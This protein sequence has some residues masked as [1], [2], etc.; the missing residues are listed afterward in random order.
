MLGKIIG[1]LTGRH[2]SAPPKS[3]PLIAIDTAP[4][5]QSQS[6]FDLPLFN[7]SDEAPPKS[8]TKPNA[9]TFMKTAEASPPKEEPKPDLFGNL[10]VKTINPEPSKTTA[11]SSFSF[12]NKEPEKKSV[13]QGIDLDFAMS[14]APEP[15]PLDVLSSIDLE[16]AFDQPQRT[17]IGSQQPIFSQGK[18]QQARPY[19][20]PQG[21]LQGMNPQP[22]YNSGIRPHFIVPGAQ[23]QVS[24]TQQSLYTKEEAATDK[25]DDKY[26]GFVN[27]EL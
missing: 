21:N 7:K 18:V 16:T 1:H 3:S 14:S 5:E 26:F 2:E 23:S 10:N 4:Q 13:L 22:F 19:F 15:K 20:N 12:L 17:L 27:D 11:K 8:N 24:P 25:I 6:I 9:F